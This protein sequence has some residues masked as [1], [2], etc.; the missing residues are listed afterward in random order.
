MVI[1]SKL[2]AEDLIKRKMLVAPFDLSL[3]GANYYL[4]TLEDTADRPDVVSLRNWMQKN[5]HP[6]V[7][8]Y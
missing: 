5:M 3:P 2:L 6:G 8:T 4:V 1:A 7:R